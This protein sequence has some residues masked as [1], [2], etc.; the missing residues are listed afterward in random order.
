[1]F[2]HPRV[3]EKTGNKIKFINPEINIHNSENKYLSE[4]LENICQTADSHGEITCKEINVYI[5]LSDDIKKKIKIDNGLISQA[6]VIELGEVSNIYAESDDA[7]VFALTTF[8]HIVQDNEIFESFIF[9]YP[10]VKLRG[11]HM[12]L[13]ARDKI[14][15]FK[16][17]IDDILV[18]YKYNFIMLEIGGAMEYKKHPE[19]NNE[20]EKFCKKLSK[21]GEA[22][23]LQHYTYPWTKNSI[24]P[25]NGGGSYISQKEVKELIKYCR[26]R[27]I[28][29]IP[30][31]P[32]LS[33]SD[34]IVR[35]YPELNERIN[36]KDPDT[37]CPSNP[38]T[39]EILFDILDEVIDVFNES[40]YIHIG[41]DEVVTLCVCDKCKN[42]NPI[43]LF[44]SDIN[45]ITD[46]VESKNKKAMVACD[47]FTKLLDDEGKPYID[48]KGKVCGGCQGYEKGDIRYVPELYPSV[49]YLR[50]DISVTHWY[51]EFGFDEVF[52]DHDIIYSNFIGKQFLGWK[53][54]F[55][56]NVIGISASNWGR[57]DY[58]NMQRNLIIFDLIYDSYIGWNPEYDDNIKE[59][60]I[61]LCAKECRSFYL[62]NILKKNNNTKYIEITHT[63]DFKIPY[64]A[65]Y[66]GDY[67]EPEKYY[68]G[69][70]EITYTNGQTVYV[71][72]IY[73]ESISSSD[74]N[75]EDYNNAYLEV[76]AT[77][78]PIK[79]NNK[80]YYKWIFES[81]VQNSD[82]A[83]IN[84]KSKDDIKVE[85]I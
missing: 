22:D 53:K 80:T 18:Y 29:I 21:S 79:E 31:V 83:K 15:D 47:K 60:V 14:E 33:H 85:I 73:G 72:V 68:I 8:K 34:Y 23:K 30:E 28:T 32:S 46:Y 48:D 9:D 84:F 7:A 36:D 65:F 74:I 66:D 64:R 5:P 2:F 6:Y 52:K 62:N 43:D 25:E 59:K 81:P 78:L 45:K 17:L 51:W 26:D 11:Y 38:K 58:R 35:A 20:R 10:E 50:K 67:V 27:G 3:Y 42:K 70:Y 55:K 44:I 57:S 37:Y 41:H 13:P 49:K 61:S 82:V 12:F 39:Y 75:T 76:C 54:R 71:P 16:K 63:T 1:M 40:E 69:E 19:I 56:N 4:Y 77:A 24:H